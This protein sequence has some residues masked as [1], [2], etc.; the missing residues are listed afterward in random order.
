MLERWQC[1][2]QAGVHFLAVA[3]L[4]IL[5]V[6]C[7]SEQSK[8][9]SALV[10]GVET[11]M[12]AM[13]PTDKKSVEYT[14]A[15]LAE[16]KKVCQAAD[17]KADVDDIESAEKNY[18]GHLE[19]LDS[20][21]IKS[22]K[23]ERK[24]VPLEELRTSGD[25]NCPIGQGYEHPVLKELIKCSGPALVDMGWLDVASHFGEHG[26]RVMG[27]GD[28]LEARKDD[29]IYRYT[30]SAFESSEP[31]L[32]LQIA[33]PKA[34]GFAQ[35][36]SFATNVPIE[37]ISAD[38]PLALKR[39]ETALV[40]DEKST[41]ARVLIGKCE[42]LLPPGS[43]LVPQQAES[44]QGEPQAEEKPDQKTAGQKP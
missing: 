38:E 2:V 1:G 9:C 13:N 29:T 18:R 21:A 19:R 20:G 41:P 6:G 39:G 23:K 8:Q 40:V 15:G 28:T 24:I 25:P 36:V 35:T 10:K 12:R 17:R 31:S 5:S 34:Q 37:K 16:A 26:Y 30:Y 33:Y 7:E 22:V 44:Q 32:C 11:R 14:L 4:G 42:G 27:Q 43:P 3:C